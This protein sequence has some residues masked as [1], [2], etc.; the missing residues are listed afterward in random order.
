MKAASQEPERFTGAAG[1][2]QCIQ[3]TH[4]YPGECLWMSCIE[5]TE[6]PYCLF[7]H[8]DDGGLSESSLKSSTKCY[9]FLSVPNLL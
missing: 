9:V 4:E 5:E 8:K 2:E 1:G 3:R 7:L 6:D